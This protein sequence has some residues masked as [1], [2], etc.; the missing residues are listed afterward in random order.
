MNGTDTLLTVKDVAL[1]LAVPVSWVYLK[2]E[3]R[4]LPFLKIGR[5]VR[6]EASAIEAFIE[7]QRKNGGVR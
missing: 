1:R 7:R 5:Y 3:S 4:E 2:V 6:F